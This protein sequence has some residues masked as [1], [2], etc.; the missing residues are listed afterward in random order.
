[1]VDICYVISFGFAAR[2]LFQTGLITQLTE[3]GKTVAIITPD[4]EDE[5]L[6]EFATNPKVQIYGAKEENNIWT[7]DYLFKRKYF[8]EDVKANPALWEKHVYSLWYSGSKHPW[9]RIRPLYYGA[10]YQSVKVFPGIRNRF[11]K[12]EKKYLQSP[13][14]DD[15]IKRINPKMVVSTYPVNFLEA[16]VLFAAQKARIPT[17]LHLLSWDNITSKGIF[18]VIADFY[19]LWGEVMRQELKEYYQI[20]ANKIQVCGVP[21]FDNHF[22][23]KGTTGYK[24]L[25]SDFGLNPEAPYLFFAM[26]AKRFAPREIDIVEWLAKAIEANVFGPD[27]QLVVRPHP[28]VMTGN[29]ATKSWLT[30]LQ[31][32][33][34]KRVA[35]DFPRMVESKLKWSLKKQ[36]MNHLSKLMAGCSIC[37][38]SGSTISIE[39]LIFDKPVL[40]TS[41]DAA[42]QLP[43]WKSARRLIDYTHLKKFIALGGAT[44]TRSLSD[45]EE[46]VKIYLK[47]PQKD[48]DKRQYA[49]NQQCFESDG[50]ATGK[51][52]KALEH[53]LQTVKPEALS[54]K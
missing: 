19:I 14:T 18:P 6:K 10:I 17:T 28:Q 44:V 26:S 46:Q 33:K 27:L 37:L 30:R 8:L 47:N 49:L 54:K 20:E 31:A 5:N 9:R 7:Q 35:I 12:N 51:V 15:L 41:F 29:M 24:A 40:L 34:S 45:L 22:R 53:I 1:M 32:I 16:R 3:S 4:P 39:A 13:E 36:D 50:N 43:Y 11:Q 23:L 42:V 38:N 52:V 25:L 21:H 2:M 48:Q